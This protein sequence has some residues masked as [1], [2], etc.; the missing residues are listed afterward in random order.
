M[1]QDFI[2]LFDDYKGTD[3]QG[4]LYEILQEHN[5]QSPSPIEENELRMMID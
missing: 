4:E 3:Y 1:N 5:M 2:K